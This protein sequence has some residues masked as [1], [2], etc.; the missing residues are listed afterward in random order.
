MRFIIVIFQLF[1]RS[2][3]AEKLLTN[4]H[5]GLTDSC[6]G[7]QCIPQLTV[8]FTSQMIELVCTHSTLLTLLVHT[9]YVTY[10]KNFLMLIGIA[11]LG[12]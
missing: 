5:M 4:D 12:S 6:T 7:K 11:I 9:D 10:S 8:N 2:E 3:V 1:F